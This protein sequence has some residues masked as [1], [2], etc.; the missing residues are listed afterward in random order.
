MVTRMLRNL[1]LWMV[2]T[3]VGLPPAY[4]QS[5]A[6]A[7]RV[8]A[9]DMLRIQVYREKD[10]DREVRVDTNGTISYPLVGVIQVSG[11]TL[12]EIENLIAGRLRG[13]YFKNPTVTATII[14]Y[15]AFYVNGEVEKPGSYP[16]QPGLNVRK[17]ISVAGGL[18]ERA[19]RRKIYV[20]RDK[21]PEGREI[22]AT[23]DT[24]VGPGDIVT[25]DQSFF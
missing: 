6:E 22:K 9:G 4:A 19:S 8:D 23:L 13:R 3:G 2:V 25:V 1:F 20:I 16:Y 12:R 18:K 10:L 15:R 11:K 7:Y 17:A 14:E 5:G 24:P 21:D